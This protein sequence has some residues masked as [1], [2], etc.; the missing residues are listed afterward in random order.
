MIKWLKRW[1]SAPLFCAQLKF[2]KPRFGDSEFPEWLGKATWWSQ[3]CSLLLCL[4]QFLVYNAFLRLDFIETKYLFLFSWPWKPS[5]FLI[6]Q[7]RIWVSQLIIFRMGEI[8]FH[9]SLNILSKCGFSC[10]IWHSSGSSM[11]RKEFRKKI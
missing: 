3:I 9:P 8:P 1:N 5:G 7:L 10:G 2:P 11:L 6:Q 4:F